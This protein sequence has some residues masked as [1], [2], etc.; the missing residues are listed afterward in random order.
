MPAP[1]YPTAP[2]SS[3]EFS[4][5]R[6]KILA[7]FDLRHY[8]AVNNFSSA[9]WYV[10]LHFRSQARF[11][12]FPRRYAADEFEKQYENGLAQYVWQVIEQ[13]PIISV[14]SNAAPVKLAKGSRDVDLNDRTKS[15]FQASLRPTQ[16][17]DLVDF[18]QEYGDRFRQATCDADL[19][20]DVEAAD[21]ECAFSIAAVDQLMTDFEQTYAL[22]TIDLRASN[23]KLDADFRRWLN[24]ARKIYRP[25]SK[26]DDQRRNVTDVIKDKWVRRRVLAYLDILLWLRINGKAVGQFPWH[27]FLFPNL[28][29]LPFNDEALSDLAMQAVSPSMVNTLHLESL[30]RSPQ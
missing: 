14:H 17:R 4:A 6:E 2:E 21:D 12:L 13:N 7:W 26:N 29:E 10:N 16:P 15:L 19:D 18:Y 22:L 28:H 23:D 27:Q 5:T 9:D 20:I 11:L 8:E 1:R 24:Q 30:E 25:A 3:A